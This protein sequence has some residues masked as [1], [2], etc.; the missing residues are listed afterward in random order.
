MINLRK[1][2][3]ERR[4]IELDPDLAKH[5]L[6]Y[7]YEKQRDVRPLHVVDLAKKMENGLFRF[8][9]V[10]FASHNGTTVLIN[11]QHVC[12]AVIKSG[13]TVPCI[14]EKFKVN[15]RLEL[16]E[17]FRQFEILPRSLS[18]MVKVEAD[19]LKLKWP[20]W[21][22]SLIVSAAILEKA[23]QRKLGHTTTTTTTVSH[24][25][26]VKY[27]SK[28]DK[29]RLLGS[30]LEEGAFIADILTINGTKQSHF[31][32]KHLSRK[33]I[34]LIMMKSSRI[35]SND[36]RIF[37]ERVRDGEN[38]NRTMPEMKL[39]EFLVQTRSSIRPSA[40]AARRVSDHEYAYRCALAWNAFRKNKPTNLAY[41]PDAEVPI[42]K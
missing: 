33:A 29:V 28:D 14:L 37:W 5:Y 19:A 27:M 7:R 8:G 21:I 35:N 24:G 15:D 25:D 4:M 34:I 31:N 40:Y 9:E 22:S 23:N 20:P 16:S 30:Y 3:I 26:N 39:R 41:H 42:L 38:L 6:E 13:A 2:L 11:G 17:A 36:A 1:N 10:A 32:T 18:D 12:N